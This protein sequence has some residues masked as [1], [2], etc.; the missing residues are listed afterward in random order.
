MHNRNLIFAGTI[1]VQTVPV[2]VPV[3]FYAVAKGD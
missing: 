2:P 3:R 1:N